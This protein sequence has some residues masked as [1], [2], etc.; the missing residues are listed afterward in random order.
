MDLVISVINRVPLRAMQSNDVENSASGMKKAEQGNCAP[1]P[2]PSPVEKRAAV[3]A[4]FE[5]LSHTARER[6]FSGGQQRINIPSGWNTESAAECH[7]HPLA[8]KTSHKP[9]FAYGSVPIFDEDCFTALRFSTRS[10]RRSRI[11]RR[12]SAILCGGG[13]RWSR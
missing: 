5:A 13:S 9:A 4:A 7:V 11:L 3:W 12:S 10:R 8:F 6:P 1:E 2:N